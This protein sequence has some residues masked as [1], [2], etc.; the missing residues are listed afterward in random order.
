VSEYSDTDFTVATAAHAAA[1]G[2]LE[3]WVD[4]YLRT[5]HWANVPFADGLKLAQRWWCGPLKVKL[6]DLSPCV[7]VGTEY[8]YNIP[9]EQFDGWIDEIARQFPIDARFLPPMIV[10]YRNGELSL[11]DGNKR[12]WAMRQLG[13]T[14]CW[15]VLWFN[16]SA[17]YERFT[18]QQGEKT[19][20][21]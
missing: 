6:D 20:I 9:A 1:T 12:Y 7:G 2:Q 4:R 21:R 15:M 14:S 13:W 8:E 11:R 3:A 10:E 5:G 18:T 17:E 16:D 19:E